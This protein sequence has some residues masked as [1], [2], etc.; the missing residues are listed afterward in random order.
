V[1]CKWCNG[2]GSI[3]IEP[4]CSTR[5]RCTD[6]YGTGC[7]PDDDDPE[8]GREDDEETKDDDE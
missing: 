1:I 2:T 6:C 5:Y 4:G 8:R 7:A 3:A